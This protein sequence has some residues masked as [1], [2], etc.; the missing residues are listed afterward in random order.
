MINKV[1]YGIPSFFDFA[2]LYPSAMKVWTINRNQ[3][4]KIK[5][6]KIYGKTEDIR[7]T[8]QGA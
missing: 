7:G 2:S 5:I 3:I 6:D 1:R 4:R 8:N